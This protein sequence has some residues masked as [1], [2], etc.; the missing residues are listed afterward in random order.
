MLRAVSIC[1][2]IFALGIAPA[3]GQE[4]PRL[5]GSG[6]S[7]ANSDKGAASAARDKSNKVPPENR[8]A[9]KRP[10]AAGLTSAREAAAMAFVKQHH[11]ELVE[12]LVYLK[13][14][15]P[16]AYEQA[17][18]DL[19]RT[20]ERLAQQ[21]EINLDRYENDLALWKVESRIELLAARIKMAGPDSPEGESLVEQ[22]KGLLEE[23]HDLRAER[24]LHER[25]RI[26]ERVEKIDRQLET[27]AANREQAIQR[28]LNRFVAPPAPVKQPQ[29]NN[30]APK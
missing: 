5:S 13:E 8:Q 29:K 27:M 30:R 3:T 14:N 20:S 7:S 2:A 26:T 11:P 28:E 24:L 15:R 23:R 4:D 22:L 6:P 12:L 18:L 25:Q 10:S 1:L 17:A 16:A 21:K 9:D 19:F